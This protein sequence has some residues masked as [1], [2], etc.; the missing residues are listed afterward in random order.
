MPIK[1]HDYIEIEYTGKVKDTAVVFDTTV[2]SV[3]KAHE[4]FKEKIT[5]KPII[6]C[7]G[8]QH[9]LKGLDEQIV[10]KEPGSYTIE[11]KD[12]DAFGKKDPKLLKLIPMKVFTKE[13]IRPFVGLDLDIDGQYGIVRSVN[14]GRVIVDFNHPL[15]SR[16]L[17]YDIEI[18]RI[19]TDPNEKIQALL[20]IIGVPYESVS[21]EG[22][23]ASI[24][25]KLEMPK[26]YLK[27]IE[28]EILETIPVK[29]IDFVMPK[30]PENET[31]KDKGEEKGQE[32]SAEDSA[33]ESAE[34]ESVEEQ[35][36]DAKAEDMTEDTE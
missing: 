20:V 18:K 16:D 30:K 35:S 6:V 29:E 14:G 2:E 23:K 33:K 17:T 13:G 7:V 8:K 11:V 24:L 25:L 28:T 10:G 27:S 9:L 5:Y 22:E 26:E 21:V 19:V 34:E 15:S 3:A 12:V 1:K 4:L 32:K 31:D 36:V